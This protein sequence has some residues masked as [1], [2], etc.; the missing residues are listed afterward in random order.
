V[1]SSPPVV[2][3]DICVVGA[4]PAG[5]TTACDLLRA[6]LEVL[7]LEAGPA[8]PSRGGD[9]VDGTDSVGLPYPLDRS[10]AAGVGGSGLRWDIDTPVGGP[11]VRLRA[12]DALDLEP[13]P[14]LRGGWPLA[15][16]DLDPWYARAWDTFGLRPLPPEQVD[17]APAP[18]VAADFTFG[19]AATF[20][21]RLP[22]ELQQAARGRL[23]AG[24]RVLEVLTGD[25]GREVT[26]L[27]CTGPSGPLTV[28][29]RRYVLA[30]GGVENARLLLASRSSGPQ[31][32]GNRHDQVGRFFMEHPHYA[33]GVLVV[34]D[35]RLLTQPE[36]W[37]V[38]GVDGQARM[39]KLRLS[40]DVLRQHDLPGAAFFVTP[41]AARK[42]VHV[43][44]AGTLDVE[45]TTAV[46]Q[47]RMALLTR[48]RDELSGRDVRRAIAGAPPLIRSAWQ[49]RRALAGHR[50]GL[51]P[52]RPV[53][54]TLSVMAEQL[55]DPASRVRLVSARDRWGVPRAELDWRVA[56]LDRCAM[57]RRH[58]LA[59]PALER[60]F[61]GT[62]LSFV[63]ALAEPHMGEGYHH[64][65]TTRMSADPEE[66][67]VDSD[68]RV[69]G[70]RNLWVAG[71]SVFA[72]G[73]Y[74][75]PTLTVVALAHR[76][77]DRLVQETRGA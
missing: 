6:G 35:G 33:S 1:H 68:C 12:L 3:A 27:R 5:L 75:N 18:L 55:P 64:M 70:M 47:L 42:P 38:V 52:D 40:D 76:L 61:G 53:V 11:F 2:T 46:H 43:D 56:E 65:G 39:R 7:V 13:R 50:H 9:V 67:V 21:E 20:T 25:D 41:R 51:P 73:G 66:G 10:R 8:H 49:Q 60:A 29:A 16:D 37:A 44:A 34:P 48:R 57:A 54:F 24:T 58:R 19:R 45:L 59:A 22:R 23:L 31:G 63:D 26:G 62:V 74:A 14:G 28:T 69:H 72:T 77:A 32:L 36:R 30:G 71:S 17:G 15:R 4:G